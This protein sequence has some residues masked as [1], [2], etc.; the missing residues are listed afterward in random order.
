MVEEAQRDTRY[1]AQSHKKAADNAKFSAQ[2][3][4]G[5]IAAD[6]QSTKRKFSVDFMKRC[7]AEYDQAIR[8][9]RGN[10]EKLINTLSFATDAIIDCY[11]GSVAPPVNN[12][13]WCAVVFLESSGLKSTSH[14]RA[15][16]YI[17]QRVTRKSCVNWSTSDSAVQPL[18]PPGTG[19]IPRNQR[20]YTEAIPNQIQKMLPVPGTFNPRSSPPYT[21]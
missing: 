5:R 16:H 8:K 20:P 1:L 9:H 7:T 4:S 11:S 15:E 18:P 19:Q 17:P 2:M 3:F 6:R 21:A 14:P 12:I 13:P 10:A